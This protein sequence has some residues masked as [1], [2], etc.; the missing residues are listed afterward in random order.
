QGQFVHEVFEKFFRRWEAEGH[1]AVTP[2]N[3]ADARVT[4][5]EVVA[6]SF[7]ARSS[8]EAPL[9]RTRLL[10]SSAAAGLGEAVLR[11]EAERPGPVVERPLGN[12][13]RRRVTV[14][15]HARPR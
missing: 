4:F 13:L 7:G 8:T 11:M 1:L 12:H 15:E 5:E 9:D 2:D 10:G 3:L 14:T 6:E